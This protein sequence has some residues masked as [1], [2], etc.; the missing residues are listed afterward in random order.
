MRL[1]KLRIDIE[2]K[3]SQ[4]EQMKENRRRA[5]PSMAACE[6]AKKND[7]KELTILEGKEDFEEHRGDIEAEVSF[8]MWQPLL[9]HIRTC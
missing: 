2:E 1:K 8:L 7:K 6:Q 9:R 5:A 3:S 4:L